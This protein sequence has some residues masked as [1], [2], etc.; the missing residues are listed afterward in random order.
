M[1]AAFHN[2]S[3][4]ITMVYGNGNSMSLSCCLYHVVCPCNL[5]VDVLSFIYFEIENG[6][7][8]LV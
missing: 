8:L 2:Q 7:K 6:V 4:L 3:P 1:F 5:I